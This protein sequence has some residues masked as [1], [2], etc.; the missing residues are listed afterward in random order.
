MKKIKKFTTCMLALLFLFL[1]LKDKNTT[2]AFSTTGFPGV[3]VTPYQ[4]VE[5]LNLPEGTNHSYVVT[6]FG[7]R[8]AICPMSYSSYKVREGLFRFNNLMSNRNFYRETL[9]SVSYCTPAVY[10]QI[11]P[12]ANFINGFPIMFI[13]Q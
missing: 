3:H 8:V 6:H 11:V 10:S 5:T 2:Q 7:N 12:N 9:H 4:F 13:K 1:F